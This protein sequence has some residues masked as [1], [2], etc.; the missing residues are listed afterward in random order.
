MNA[1]V[2][3]A[4][5]FVGRAM[6][7]RLADA[8]VLAMGA[9]DW[10]ANAARTDFAGA[11]VWHLA[12]RVHGR[13]APWPRWH[14]DN[15]EKTEALAR[16]AARGG[17]RRFVFAS[18]LK[19]HGEESGAR[20]FRSDDPL[21]PEG[22]YARSKALAEERLAVVARETGLDVVIVRA[23]LVFGRDAR[24]NLE[25][26]VRLAGRPIPLPF[27]GIDN[28]RSWVHVDDLCGLLVACGEQ[29][30]AS[31]RAFIACHP[32]SFSTPRLFRELRAR[33]GREPRL[34][35]APAYALE[36]AAAIVGR[37]AALRPLTRSLEGDST[38]AMRHLGWT[39]AV[40]FEG[41]VADL[42]DA[43]KP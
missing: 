24:A 28:R 37:G 13:D 26:A 20:P 6:A 22:H 42:V 19:V 21:R 25:S 41:A 2:T 18:T 39:P 15:V 5:G 16:A 29:P 32:D 8:Q 34:F 30:A 17:A 10:R 40:S 1:V 23:P 31:G 14:A 12:A 3:G 33:L 4:S 27:A 36:A 9:A 11:H 35:S 38:E 7:A 43:R